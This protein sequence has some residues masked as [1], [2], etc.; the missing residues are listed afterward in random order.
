MNVAA[1]G[2]LLGLAGWIGFPFAT[3]SEPEYFALPRIPDQLPE[4]TPIELTIEEAVL[5]VLE[6]NYLVRVDAEDVRIADGGVQRQK[7]VFEPLLSGGGGYSDRETDIVDTETTTADAEIRKSF[8]TGTELSFGA[9]F[10]D[11]SSLTNDL[12]RVTLDLSQPL[13]RN[14]GVRVNRADLEIAENNLEVAMLNLKDRMIN[15]AAS[16]QNDYWALTAS[17]AN[18]EV[19][20]DSLKYAVELFELT[21]QREDAGLVANADTVEAQAAVYD[22]EVNVVRGGETVRIL[23]DNLKEQLTLFE[24]PATWNA[25]IIPVTPPDLELE[26]VAF[27]GSL[28]TALSR[29]PDYNREM[30]QLRNV[31]EDLYVAKNALLPR[32]DLVARAERADEQEKGLGA[33]LEALLGS[34]DEFWSVFLRV[35]VPLGNKDARGRRTQTEARRRQQLLRLKDLELQILREVRRAV[36]SLVTAAEVVKSTSRAVE[37][38]QKKLE[39]ERAKLEMGESNTDNIVRFIESLNRAQLRKIQA[40]VDYNV[41]NVRLE[42]VR[43]TTLDSYGIHFWRDE[44]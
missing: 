13:L 1:R 38:E 10:T 27:V 6:F 7:A 5:G 40:I 14:F 20:Q 3:L 30:I 4:S 19:Q 25:P 34:N 39:N 33:P 37:F 42:R 36:D 43:G 44:N 15:E 16:I 9:A 31:D 35:E 22:R 8:V 21:Q 29:R 18:L 12:G 23:E 11:D 17:R 41:S 2:A 32:L 26:E 28:A 24:N